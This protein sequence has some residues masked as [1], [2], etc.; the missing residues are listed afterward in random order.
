MPNYSVHQEVGGSNRPA[1][2]MARHAF[3]R[4]GRLLYRA[5]V[6][7]LVARWPSAGGAAP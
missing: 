3:T 7:G 2:L 5:P 4:G 1:P 6:D